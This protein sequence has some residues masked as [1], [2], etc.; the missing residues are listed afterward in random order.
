V[1]GCEPSYFAIK[2]WAAARGDLFDAAAEKRLEVDRQDDEKGYDGPN[3]M[4][5]GNNGREAVVIGKLGL[6]CYHD[7]WPEL[8][9]VWALAI[10]T[11]DNPADDVWANRGPSAG[12]YRRARAGTAAASSPRD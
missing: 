9:P 1:V 4:I 8:H 2:S 7:C 5:G 11:V 3:R 6:D 12:G 10:H